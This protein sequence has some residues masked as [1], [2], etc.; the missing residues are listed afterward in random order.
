M[1]VIMERAERSSGLALLVGTAATFLI[2]AGLQ[3]VSG[4]VGPAFLALVLVIAVSPLRAW[5]ERKGAPVWVSVAVPLTT[6]LVTLLALVAAVALSA[7]QLVLLLPSYSQKFTKLY[8]DLLNTLAGYG[9]D[10]KRLQTALSKIDPGQVFSYVE[11]F[12]SGLLSASSM[13]LVVVL[14]LVGL[15]LDAVGMSR[16]FDDLMGSRPHLVAALR[17]FARNTTQYL[18]VSSVFGLIVA[19]LDTGVL[20]LFDI[21]LPLLWGLLSFLT[22]Y[23][24]NIGFVVGLAPP[25]LLALLDGGWAEMVWVIVAYCVINFVLQSL[26]QPKF[27]G[28]AVGLNVTLTT[29]SLLLWAVVLGPLGAILAIPLSSLVKAL[30]VDADPTKWW[31]NDL[32]TSGR[33]VPEQPV[34]DPA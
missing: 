6:I 24:P 30:L 19:V 21:P 27:M 32:I 9:I 15:C 2:L 10:E 14:V 29:L 1:S 16:R 31:L 5:L 22:N 23:I 20:Y 26:I 4:I 33:P 18:I 11:S 3:T 25:A 8:N 28:D 17:G 12:L 34:E 7:A 13:I